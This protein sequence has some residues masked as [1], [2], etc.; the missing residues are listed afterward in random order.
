MS[1]DPDAVLVLND[2]PGQANTQ[3][4]DGDCVRDAEPD[5][6]RA[7]GR[8]QDID[9]TDP[10]QTM[11]TF[12]F[13]AGLPGAEMNFDFV[14]FPI[15]FIMCV[16]LG[17]AVIFICWTPYMLDRLFPIFLNT[18]FPMTLFLLFVALYLVVSLSPLLLRLEDKGICSHTIFALILLGLWFLSY[19]A[20]LFYLPAADG[21]EYPYDSA[22]YSAWHTGFAPQSFTGCEARVEPQQSPLFTPEIYW[23]QFPRVIQGGE[24]SSFTKF[25]PG[26]SLN[27]RTNQTL[28]YQGFAGNEDLYG[29]GIRIGIYLQWLAALLVNNLLPDGRKELQKVYLIFNI[30]LCAAA[31]ESTF[32]ERCV[33]GIEIEILY[34]LYWGGLICVS[35]SSPSRTRLTIKRGEWIGLDWRTA[36]QYTTNVLMAYHTI[37]FVWLAYDRVFSRMPCGTYQFLF[38]PVLDPSKTFC[39]LR[40]LLMPVI[41]TLVFPFVLSVPFLV[42][43]LTSEIKNSV[44]DSTLCQFFFPR[45]SNSSDN[46]QPGN[47]GA[48]EVGTGEGLGL[49]VLQRLGGIYDGIKGVYRYFRVK[50]GLPVRGRRGIRLITPIDIKDRRYVGSLQRHTEC[51]LL[52]AS[53]NYRIRCA[54][55]GVASLIISITAVEATLSWNKVVNVYSI[56]STGQYIPFTIGVASIIQVFW[57]LA[58][59]EVVGEHA[60]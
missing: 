38:M 47:V 34:W 37:W 39:L 46:T 35:A 20:L 31:Y 32:T 22:L 3:V 60:N 7:A 52:T 41:N 53:R 14:I 29:M 58:K 57:Q 36:I 24:N 30:A 10:S 42:V 8:H 19:Y 45:V 59:Q 11:H 23:T 5:H 6:P 9:Y 15:L 27:I 12:S 4:H 54:A 33:F 25:D 56:R 51:R 26:P 17:V 40:D 50:W 13:I 2:P 1:L 55:S 48:P 49:R 18:M 16:I 28:C 21:L 43:V 44:R